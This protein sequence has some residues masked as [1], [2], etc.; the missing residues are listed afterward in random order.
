[1]NKVVNLEYS[2]H[3]FR[4]GMPIVIGNSLIRKFILKGEN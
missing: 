3:H 1:M 2:K 4:Y